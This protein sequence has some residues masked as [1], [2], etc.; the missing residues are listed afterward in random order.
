MLIEHWSLGGNIK[1]IRPRRA[2]LKDFRPL[3]PLLPPCYFT[4]F[5]NIHLLDGRTRLN[6]L[7]FLPI[8]I[9][10]W[11]IAITPPAAHHICGKQMMSLGVSGRAHILHTKVTV[12]KN[13]LFSRDTP[14]ISRIMFT[15]GSPLL[16]SGCIREVNL[17]PPVDNDISEVVAAQWHPKRFISYSTEPI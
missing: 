15:C 14:V 7:L 5:A 1:Y 13:T 4:C 16:Y 11:N 6:S 10:N 9:T 17:P 12:E 3:W 2:Q 8:V